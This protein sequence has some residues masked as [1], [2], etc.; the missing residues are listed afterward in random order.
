MRPQNLHDIRLYSGTYATRSTT[1]ST[2]T[3]TF[4]QHASTNFE[5]QQPHTTTTTTLTTTSLPYTAPTTHIDSHYHYL[6]TSPYISVPHPYIPRRAA[7]TFP[8]PGARDH[9]TTRSTRLH[10]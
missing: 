9:S 3:S 8:P 7:H 1:A 5:F 6:F 2:C 10:F 4:T